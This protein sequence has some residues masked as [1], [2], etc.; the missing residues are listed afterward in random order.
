MTNYSEIGGPSASIA[1]VELVKVEADTFIR[2]ETCGGMDLKVEGGDL[3]VVSGAIHMEGTS[4]S[5]H[6]IGVKS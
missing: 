2:V 3:V 1:M 6:Y 5:F 4:S